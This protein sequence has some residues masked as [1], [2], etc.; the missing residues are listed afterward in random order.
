MDDVC[1]D[2]AFYN[3]TVNANYVR[4]FFTFGKIIPWRIHPRTDYVEMVAPGRANAGEYYRVFYIVI[5]CRFP[6][7]GQ[8]IITGIQSDEDQI[9]Y[10]ES[11][12]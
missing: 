7:R 3:K 11:I 6:K 9:F 12:N 8:Y 2:T 5:F 1:M 4:G 10:R